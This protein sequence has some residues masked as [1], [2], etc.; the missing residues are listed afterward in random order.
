MS[1]IENRTSFTAVFDCYEKGSLLKRRVKVRN[2][3]LAEGGLV[4]DTLIFDEETAD[5]IQGHLTIGEYIAFTAKV[6]F[7]NIEFEYP[8]QISS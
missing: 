8:H 3:R 2:I 7:K 1:N 5:K 4:R 6:E